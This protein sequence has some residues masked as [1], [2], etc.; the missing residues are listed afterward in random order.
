MFDE[1]I[2][3]YRITGK[4]GVGGMGVVYDAQDE[5]LPRRVAL[6]FLPEELAGDADATRRLRREAQTIA[7][8]NHPQIC[9]I[10]EVD[11]HKG[12]VFIVMERL[13][14]R[15]SRS[16]WRGRPSRRPR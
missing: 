15:T 16:T 14:A 9:T 10:Y 3:H 13:E 8:L 4:L 6:K 1:R 11:E 7:L 5:R 12:R 2:S